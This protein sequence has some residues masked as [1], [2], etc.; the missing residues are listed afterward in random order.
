[1]RFSSYND[2]LI[3]YYCDL[4]T[5]TGTLTDTQI[6]MHILS[7]ILSNPLAPELGAP[8]KFSLGKT[9]KNSEKNNASRQRDDGDAAANYVDSRI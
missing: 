7:R 1:M 2:G 5:H 4:R 3:V 9:L 6:H 8:I